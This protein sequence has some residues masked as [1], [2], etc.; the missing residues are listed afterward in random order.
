MVPLIEYELPQSPRVANNREFN[1][2]SLKT[3]PYCPPDTNQQ[4]KDITG[5]KARILVKYN[6]FFRKDNVF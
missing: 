2:N 3:L 4:Y 5:E 1:R 6:L